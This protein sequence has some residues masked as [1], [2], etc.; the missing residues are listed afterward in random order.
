[1][2]LYPSRMYWVRVISHV[3]HRRLKAALHDNKWGK[4]PGLQQ[5]QPSLSSSPSVIASTSLCWQYVP[6]QW[7]KESMLP[8][9]GGGGNKGLLPS[10]KS[11]IEGSMH[12]A[13]SN[14]KSYGKILDVL[15]DLCA[16]ANKE[17]YIIYLLSPIKA[18]R[19][20]SNVLGVQFYLR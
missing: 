20:W 3:S 12:L 6:W 5:Q 11:T 9:I 16:V 8:V 13:K 15:I 2:M 1:M 17:L 14:R 7:E 19:A 18:K 4:C 10:W